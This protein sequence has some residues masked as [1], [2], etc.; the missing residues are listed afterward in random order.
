MGVEV[1]PATDNHINVTAGNL[2]ATPTVQPLLA[3]GA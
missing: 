2:P 1:E 3:R